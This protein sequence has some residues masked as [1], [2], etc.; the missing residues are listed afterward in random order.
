MKS[1]GFATYG[2]S[3]P[4]GW[5]SVNQLNGLYASLQ[6]DRH[7]RVIARRDGYAYVECGSNGFLVTKAQLSTLISQG[8]TAIRDLETE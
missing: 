2:S 7:V 8:L 4:P 3:Y 6:G 5:L 1:A